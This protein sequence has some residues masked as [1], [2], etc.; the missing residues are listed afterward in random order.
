MTTK[1]ADWGLNKPIVDGEFDHDQAASSW[2]GP[3]MYE[4]VYN[5]GYAGAWGWQL[6]ESRFAYLL[7]GVKALKGKPGV[8]FKFTDYPNIPDTCGSACS[9]KAPDSQYTCAQQAAWGKCTE[10]WMKGY[11]C[12]SCF[13]CQGCSS[14]QELDFFLQK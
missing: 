6:I 7:D 9:D 13:G 3:K 4:T 11:C 1:A 8:D 12:R 2:S 10:S 5:N 14:A